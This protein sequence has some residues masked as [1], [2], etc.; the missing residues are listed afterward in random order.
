MADHLGVVE[1]GSTTRLQIYE[2]DLR[3][4][5]WQQHHSLEPVDATLNPFVVCNMWGLKAVYRRVDHHIW[6]FGGN[7]DV[8]LAVDGGISP[9]GVYCFD[10]NTFKWKTK[11]NKIGK[12]R[13]KAATKN[14]PGSSKY[15]Y[16]LKDDPDITASKLGETRYGHAM[17]MVMDQSKF[18]CKIIIINKQIVI[19]CV[20]WRLRKWI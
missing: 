16:S 11:M 9:Y 1:T 18:V 15:P 17:E 2:F 10:L 14:I 7:L 4:G 8:M 5:V 3:N 12:L 19:G 13:W 6:C 20:W